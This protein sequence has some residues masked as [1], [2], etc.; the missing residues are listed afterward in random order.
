MYITY[1]IEISNVQSVLYELLVYGTQFHDILLAVIIDTYY[2]VQ[3]VWVYCWIPIWYL[4]LE[5]L[6]MASS[7]KSKTWSK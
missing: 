6:D 7:Q 5:V 2:T 3:N 4:F 1:A